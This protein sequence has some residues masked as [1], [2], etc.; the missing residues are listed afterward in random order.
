MYAGLYVKHCMN[1]QH[2]CTKI[3]N[4]ELSDYHI[5]KLTYQHWYWSQFWQGFY[6]DFYMEP[7]DMVKGGPEVNSET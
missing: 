2:I 5:M 1:I 3:S 6:V 4:T 7:M